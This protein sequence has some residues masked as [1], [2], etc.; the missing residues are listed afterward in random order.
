MLDDR[1]AQARAA[2]RAAASRIDAVES[3]GQPRDM[4]RRDAVAFVAD[5][6]ADHA[7]GIA[8]QLD[9]DRRA[10]AAVFHRVADQIVQRLAQLGAVAGHRGHI[11]GELDD[12]VGDA[13]VVR[14]AQFGDDLVEQDRQVDRGVGHAIFLRLDP[15]Q[16]DQ[17]LDQPLH[18]PRLVDHHLQE[19][20]A[21]RRVGA[22]VLAQRLGEAQDR[23][24]RRAQFVA[25]IGDEIDSHPLGGVAA[26]LI[27]QVD[28]AAAV[29]D[30]GDSQFPTLVERA[31]PDQIDR[32]GR[33]ATPAAQSAVR[34]RRDGG[35]PAA[36]PGR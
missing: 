5:R 27:D 34:R 28:D 33:A 22:V 32:T 30:V 20:L 12:D 18:P 13:R 25:G 9:R 17:I 31:E 16:R 11:V 14:V 15:A 8:P 1:E 7:V 4:L 26:G 35:S 10:R 19:T 24:E 2:D 3:L 21:H 23:G 29:R 6:Q 36:R